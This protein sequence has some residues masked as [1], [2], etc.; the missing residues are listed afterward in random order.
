M[1]RYLTAGESH[2]PGLICILD[3]CPAGLEINFEEINE[4]AFKFL[5]RP[6]QTPFFLYLHGF[7]AHF[8]HNLDPPYDRWLDE[9]YDSAHIEQ[10][11]VFGART[12]KGGEFSAADK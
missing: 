11:N 5:A 3:G 4:E 2:G 7:D 9:N 10:S 6:H 1:I 8:P 12:T